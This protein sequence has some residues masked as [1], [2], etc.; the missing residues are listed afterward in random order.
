[1]KKT[2][3]ALMITSILASSLTGC[4][5]SDEQLRM[6]AQAAAFQKL[7]A[8]QEQAKLEEAEAEKLAAEQAA[9]DD[10]ELAGVITELKKGDPLVRDAYYGFNEKGDRVLHVVRDNPPQPVQPQQP[11]YQQGAN[12]QPV[13]INN[14]P[15]QAASSGISETIWP[16]VAG[17]GAGML[18]ANA[19]NSSGG[20]DRYRDSHQGYS[21]RYYNDD[22]D[23]RRQRTTVV[24]QYHTTN[25]RNVKAVYKNPESPAAK[26]Y[27]AQTGY[28]PR[29][30][31]PSAYNQP[32]TAA[33]P[34]GY[35][36]RS[37]R[38]AVYQQQQTKQLDRQVA[39]KPMTNPQVNSYWNEKPKA[40]PATS[41]YNQPKTAASPAVR[42]ATS[43]SYKPASTSSYKPSSSSSY[44]SSSP[45]R[46]STRR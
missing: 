12:G 41:N 43:S 25:V 16:L 5:K 8:D 38:S 44:K 11:Q 6:E 2:L 34:T 3:I 24:N 31:A 9:A 42:P 40:Q 14:Q 10:K 45:S 15:A 26:A 13:I 20:F 1:M 28:K 33:S 22:N 4:G 46:S 29:V 30:V 17:A 32:K 36:Q 7:Q 23:Y 37:E 39:A 18:L 27:Q 21:N 35:Q 19:M